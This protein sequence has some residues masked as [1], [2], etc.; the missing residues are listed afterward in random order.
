MG[1]GVLGCPRPGAAGLWSCAPTAPRS[2]PARRMPLTAAQR[3]HLQSCVSE[4]G[5]PPAC[6]AL[7]PWAHGSP[8]PSNVLLWHQNIRLR[9]AARPG[10]HVT[11]RR[12]PRAPAAGCPGQTPCDAI[13]DWAISS[14]PQQGGEELG[15]PMLV[16]GSCEESG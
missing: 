13:G 9:T 3:W 4:A 1:V 10:T 11:P 7:V 5:D 2:S 12:L 6:L 16:A 15:K 14:I 8:Q